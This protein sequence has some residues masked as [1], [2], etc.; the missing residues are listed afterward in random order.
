MNPSS[1]RYGTLG[2][3]L[4]TSAG[5][6]LGYFAIVWSKLRTQWPHIV[7]S[8]VCARPTQS[9]SA[10]CRRGS[11]S[12]DRRCRSLQVIGAFFVVLNILLTSTTVVGILSWSGVMLSTFSVVPC[13]LAVSRLYPLRSAPPTPRPPGSQPWS[14]P[15]PAPINAAGLAGGTRSALL[16]LPYPPV[17][18]RR[19]ALHD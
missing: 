11:R 19:R 15:H 9:K 10:V 5:V 17:R 12:F 8:G 16:C 18:C 6:C 2:H 13:L 1:H 4:A 14:R 3:G 7:M